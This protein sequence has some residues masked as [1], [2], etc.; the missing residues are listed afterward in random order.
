MQWILARPQGRSSSLRSG[1]S[2]LT[3]LHS[4]PSPA[5]PTISAH[6]VGVVYDTA[7]TIIGGTSEYP[8]LAAV[9]KTIRLDADLTFMGEP[10]S[11]KAFPNYG[12]QVEGDPKRRRPWRIRVCCTNW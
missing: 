3:P 10:A 6:R 7:G 1:R 8:G 9:G 5:R 11:C 2:T 12:Y 4:S